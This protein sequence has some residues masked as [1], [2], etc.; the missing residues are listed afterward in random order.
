MSY[1]VRLMQRGDIAQVIE[2]DREAFPNMWP[3]ANY[4]RE[5]KNRLAH[6]VV[7]CDGRVTLEADG[8]EAPREE[9]STN[10]ASRLKRLFNHD[11][12]FREELP[13]PAKQHIAG[14]AGF[15]IMAGEAHIISIAVRERHRGRVTP[16]ADG[17]ALPD[18]LPSAAVMAI[19]SQGSRR[20]A[21]RISTTTSPPS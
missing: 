6:Y 8:A 2:I 3:P 4:E 11:R 20:C 5:M 10:L 18:H 12:F 13:L 21:P 7:A 17:F 1:Y 14:F 15:W 16:A 19:H 9:A